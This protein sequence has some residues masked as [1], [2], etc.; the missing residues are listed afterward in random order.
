MKKWSM[1]LA[2]ALLAPVVWADQAPPPPPHDKQSTEK[3]G[4]RPNSPRRQQQM[5]MRDFF[6]TLSEQE[7]KELRELQDSDPEKAKKFLDERLEK[8]NKMIRER[9]KR[10]ADLVRTYQSGSKEEKDKAYAEIRKITTEDFERN[11]KEHKRQ[12]EFLE[13]RL[14]RE[15]E[16][17]DARQKNAEAIIQARIDELTKPA[18]LRW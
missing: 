9:E 5:Q 8:Y 3:S 4:E 12:L 6:A 14:E 17:Y 13:K 7:R 1:I 10:L 15:R 18:E 2:A 11:L 16:K